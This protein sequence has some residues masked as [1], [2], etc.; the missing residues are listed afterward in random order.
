MI[1]PATDEDLDWLMNVAG[2]AYPAGTYDQQAGRNYWRQIIN[3]PVCHMYRG[4][5]SAMAAMLVSMPYAPAQKFATLL[6][7][8]SLGNAGAELMI[9]TRILLDWAKEQGAS[10]FDFSAITGV[11][12]GPLARR[13]GGVPVSPA[14][15]VRFDHV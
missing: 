4:E 10:R 2:T 15:T 11:D 1:R 14:Y 13:F 6:P 3:S 7:V 5:R 8:M 12:L 9:M